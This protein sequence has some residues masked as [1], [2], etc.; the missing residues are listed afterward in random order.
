MPEQTKWGHWLRGLLILLAGI[1]LLRHAYNLRYHTFVFDSLVVDFWLLLGVP[2]WVWSIIRAVQRFQKA[3]QFGGFAIP[4]LGLAFVP[5]F[6]MVKRDG[7]AAFRK[8]T[9]LRVYYDGDFNGAGFDFKTD[10]TYIFD[11]FCLGSNF[12]YGT[13]KIAGNKITLDRDT[14]DYFAGMKHLE[15]RWT[16][17]HNKPL[18]WYLL[19]VDTAGKETPT[20]WPCR[21]VVDNRK[22]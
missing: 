3:G 2:V 1:M 14:A 17:S 18:D 20:T 7:Q 19:P 21:V 6:W 11:D 4:I 9:L 13:Y 10:G 12:T 16:D 15:V 22:K 5:V 8:P